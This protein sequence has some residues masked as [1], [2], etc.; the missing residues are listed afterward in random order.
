MLFRS[1]KS[2][3]C[4]DQ[5]CSLICQNNP[6]NCVDKNAEY[7]E[8][9]SRAEAKLYNFQGETLDLTWHW[10]LFL[11]V[12]GNNKYI[13]TTSAVPISQ[14]VTFLTMG[15]YHPSNKEAQRLRTKLN[16]LPLKSWVIAQS[17]CLGKHSTNCLIFIRT[18]S[19]LYSKYIWYGREI[20]EGKAYRRS[21]NSLGF[22]SA[23]ILTRANR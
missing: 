21:R 17:L 12:F 18:T 10:E 1:L 16:M 23:V 19:E 20:S 11:H 9:R 8:W 3:A 4:L 2:S 22:L 15:D 13:S 5:K 6:F 7:Q 14:L